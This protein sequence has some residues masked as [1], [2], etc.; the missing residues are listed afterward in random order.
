M[1][2]AVVASVT[3]APARYDGFDKMLLNGVVTARAA[4]LPTTSI[5]IPTKSWFRSN[6]ALSFGHR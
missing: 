4:G 5:P 6:V 1:G 3:G 2:K